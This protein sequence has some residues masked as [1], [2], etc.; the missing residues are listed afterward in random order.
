MLRAPPLSYRMSAS[1]TGVIFFMNTLAT[2]F[3]VRSSCSR[4]GA[5][6]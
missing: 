5:A 1:F 4:G 2:P 6:M 3:H